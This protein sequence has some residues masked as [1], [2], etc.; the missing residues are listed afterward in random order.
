M[1]GIMAT[2]RRNL[3][4]TREKLKRAKAKNDCRMVAFWKKEIEALD[5]QR[6]KE[7]GERAIKRV[8]DHTTQQ[9]DRLKDIVEAEGKATRDAIKPL[10][11][12]VSENGDEATQ[13]KGK[14]NKMACS[15]L[16]FYLSLYFRLRFC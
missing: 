11:D 9:A 1:T 6:L 7:R 14:E 8:N 10:T 3:G 4:K 2:S 13:I 16:R 15:T 12:L 5:S